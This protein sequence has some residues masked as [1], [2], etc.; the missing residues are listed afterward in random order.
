MEKESL[1]S[2]GWISGLKDSHCPQATKG[3]PSAVKGF[4]RDGNC[5]WAV[6]DSRI[7]LDSCALCI[8]MYLRL[9]IKIIS[10]VWSNSTFF[11]SASFAWIWISLRDLR[12]L[13]RCTW[14][15][16]CYEFFRRS[17]LLWVFFAALGGSF[18]PAFWDRVSVL[19]SVVKQSKKWSYWT[20]WLLKMVSLGCAETSVKHC[21][22]TRRWNP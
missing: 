3:L 7:Y 8:K 21:Q 12:L 9:F 6:N 16:R 14:G 13:P 15:L 11:N 4:L 5:M 2:V 18:L 20:S 1:C 22:P 17:S 19:S 10:S